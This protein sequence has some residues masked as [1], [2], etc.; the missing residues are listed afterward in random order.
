[1]VGN[2][3]KVL[4]YAKAPRATFAVRHPKQAMRIATTRWAMRNTAA[5]R[6][7]AVGAAMVALPIGLMLGRLTKRN[8]GNY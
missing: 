2:A 4:G 1:M 8:G 5:P 3:L 7:A 6:I